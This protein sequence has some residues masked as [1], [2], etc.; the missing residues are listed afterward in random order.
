MD[1]FMTQW[2]L[3]TYP[4]LS[5]AVI[6]VVGALKKLFPTWMDGKEPHLALIL[7]YALGVSTKLF[8]PGAFEKIHWI[9]FLVSLIVVAAGAKW[10]HDNIVD[11]IIA[12][13]VS[14]EEKK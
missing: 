11:R 12:N 5:V 10:G 8:V 4:G 6:A 2:D 3:V 9:V 1:T 13:K 7:S 14:P